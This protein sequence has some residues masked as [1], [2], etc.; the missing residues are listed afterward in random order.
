[1]S[2]KRIK[3]KRAK[4][5]R[6]CAL[7]GKPLWGQE[8][9]IGKTGR[10]V[11]QDC[12]RVA[13]LLLGSGKKETCPVA[14]G[15][16]TPAQMLRE[17]DKAI[18]GQ[19]DAKRAIA[20][21]FWK[22]QMRAAG[23]KLPNC[24][25]L[26][27]GPTGC[28]K[29]ALAR[30]AARIAGLPFVAFDATTLTEAGYRGNSADDMVK[31]LIEKYGKTAAKKGVVFLDEV[32]K[33]SARGDSARMAYSRGTQ[34]SLLKLIEGK[35]VEGVD[36]S[37]LLFL[38]GG[39]FTGLGKKERRMN[40]IGFERVQQEEEKHAIQME[41]FIT[42]GMERELMGRISRCVRLK[43]L[44]KAD[45]RRIL[46]ESE[47]SAFYRYEKFCASRGLK[48]EMDDE[49]EETIIQTA[50]KRGLGARGL[51]GLVE[52]WVESELMELAERGEAYEREAIHQTGG[53]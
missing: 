45:L 17:L 5:W 2:N 16:V 12:L 43:A 20:V 21:A 31:Q 36:T 44:E 32:D 33:L 11:C 14:S 38:F 34:H 4:E 30:E 15:I 18:I 39:A 51:N 29:T 22:Q 35:E 27:Y 37:G 25:L 53:F 1:M 26:L 40:A 42:F 9:V 48:L 6:S 50:L 8:R 49:T 47:L 24:G 28:G 52:E 23:A 13:G 41:D 19:E 7:C 10:G 46:R 3:K